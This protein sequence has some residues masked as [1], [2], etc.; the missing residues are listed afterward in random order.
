MS[1]EETLRHR[2]ERYRHNSDQ[3]PVSIKVRATYGCF[4]CRGC[5]PHAMRLIEE[6]RHR[7]EQDHEFHFEEHESGPEVIVYVVAGVALTTAVIN[8]VAAIIKARS[9]GKKKGDK[10][11]H[12]IEL[13][14]RGF[15][16]DGK[17]FDEVVLRLP[18][19][20]ESTRAAVQKALQRGLDKHMPPPTP[21]AALPK[22]KA[23]AK[24]KPRAQK[25]KK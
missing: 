2:L 18:P 10:T 13:I 12:P 6:A 7:H 1:W 22:P 9:D 14:V 3:L 8:F 15:D 5:A 11:D 17:L 25:R 20:D 19:G 16:G 21:P 23:A 24:P 4:W